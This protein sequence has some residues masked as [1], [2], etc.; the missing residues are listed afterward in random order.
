MP[1]NAQSL[2]TYTDAEMLN[3]YRWAL[4]NGAAGQTRTVN[5]RTITF[6]S[7]ADITATIQWLE[8]RLAAAG[9]GQNA[10]AHTPDCGRRSWPLRVG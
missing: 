8:L 7:V 1:I 2:P 9:G 4:A 10:L 3:I 5:G 6:A